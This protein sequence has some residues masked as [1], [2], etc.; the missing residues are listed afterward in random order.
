MES[1]LD[2]SNLFFTSQEEVL[3]KNKLFNSNLIP[4]KIPM[5]YKVDI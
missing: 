3:N 1:L 2:F 4:I 5:L